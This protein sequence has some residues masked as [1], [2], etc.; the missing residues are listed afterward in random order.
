MR[1]TKQP[2]LDSKKQ[3][4]QWPQP[5]T[6]RGFHRH[7]SNKNHAARESMTGGSLASSVLCGAG[8]VGVRC[9]TDA[10]STTP[11]SGGRN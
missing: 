11:H 5:V 2:R 10:R 6:M 7:R 9:G 4:Q 8:A 1:P 3:K